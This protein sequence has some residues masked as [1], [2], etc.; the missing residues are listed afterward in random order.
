MT[1]T[2][3]RTLP[4]IETGELRVDRDERV[5]YGVSTAQA[6]EALGH[7]VMLDTVTLQ[8]IV[9]QGNSKKS[10]VK[11]RFTHPGMS[12]DGMGKFLGRLKSFRLEGDKALADLH[13]SQMASKSPEGDLGE[14]VMSMAEEESDMLGLSIVFDMERVWQLESG[15]EVPVDE[16]RP[17]NA[18]TKM[19]LARVKNFVACDVVDEPAANRDGLFSSALWA[20]NQDAEQAFDQLD[21]VLSEWGISPDKAYDVAIKYFNAR[22]VKLTKGAIPMA[23]K[24]SEATQ[25]E[26]TTEQVTEL[27]TRLAAMQAQLAEQ[28][29]EAQAV[30]DALAAKEAAEA[31]ALQRAVNLESALDASN[32]RIARME[33]EARKAR[34]TAMAT[35]WAGDT[36]GHVELLEQL[37][38]GVGEDGK[39]FVF[40]VQT[41]NAISEQMATSALFD[42]IGTDKSAPEPVT[43]HDAVVAEMQASDT[44]Y[45]TASR[46]LAKTKPELYNEYVMNRGGN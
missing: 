13:L 16:D 44:D 25:P 17:E 37:A 34:F 7:N 21:T 19:P 20:S 45:D 12:N 2:R 15:E 14:Y 40:Y 38:D 24:T 41:Q 9:A 43:F 18:T 31:E 3:F 27:S 8:Q 1:T 33:A 35:D 5:I 29:A 6:V 11:S 28:K 30:K 22:G 10:G 32:E 39:A 42:E 23:D 36:A 26:V 4:L 46:K